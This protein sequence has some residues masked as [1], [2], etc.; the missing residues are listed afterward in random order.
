MSKPLDL[1]NG[2]P[3]LNQAINKYFQKK[4]TGKG[5]S[6]TDVTSDMV[7]K[8]DAASKKADDLEATGGEPN[9][10]E[11]V[12]VNGKALTPSEKA[13]NITVPT[14]NK[15]LTNGAGYQ[16]NVIE[17]VKVNGKAL[18]PS[19]KAINITVPTDNKSLT[20]GAGYQTAAQVNS[21][22]TSKG[23]QTASQVETAITS[24]SK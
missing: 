12:K 14:D 18:T 19:E 7:S 6:S 5:L 20:N 16:A 8:W 23:Y 13:I 3:A 10:I 24:V 2:L 22:I 4:E 9:V 17:T 21:A 1:E 11:T 15:S